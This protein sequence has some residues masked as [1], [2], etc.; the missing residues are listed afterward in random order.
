[1]FAAIHENALCG[2]A[3]VQTV[4]FAGGSVVSLQKELHG[5]VQVLT[6][7]GLRVNMEI[8]TACGCQMIHGDTSVQYCDW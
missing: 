4:H 5:Q 7:K 8:H 6:V 2:E 3:P 1:V